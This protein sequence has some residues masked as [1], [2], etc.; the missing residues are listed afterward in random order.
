MRRL[1]AGLGVVS[2][3]VSACSADRNEADPG[4]SSTTTTSTTS[5]TVAGSTSLPPATT[6]TVAP[7][8]TAPPP[9]NEVVI[10]NDQEP[11]TLNPYAPGGDGSIVLEIAQAIH[12]GL[13]ERDGQTLEIVPDLAVEV[14]TVANGGVVVGD[15]GITT[16]TFRIRD[17]AVW[18]DGAP[19][20]GEDVVFTYEVIAGIEDRPN[21]TEPYE[22]ITAITADGKTVTLTFG[23]PTLAFETMFPTVIPAHQVRGT[24]VMADWNEVP[25]M[26]A[27]PFR[28][29]SWVPGDRI[30]LVR[31]DD[32]WKAGPDGTALPFLDRVVFRFI[33][34]AFMGEAKQS[35]EAF[36]SRA[37]DV[38]SPPPWSETVDRLRALEG[39]QVTVLES[40]VWEHWSFQF[41]ERNRNED[42]L[43]RYLDFRRAVAHAL[44][45]QAVMNLG[46]WE[47][48]RPRDAILDLHGLPTE[49]PW[50]QYDHNPERAR[51]LISDLCDRLGRDCEAN[52][53]VVVFSTTSNAEERPAI[54]HLAVEMLG[55]VGIEVHLEF[56]DSALFFGPTLATGTWDLGQWAWF[57]RPDPAGVLTSL[58]VY[59]PDA[60]LQ[61]DPNEDWQS[62]AGSNNARW[63]TPAVSGWPTAEEFGG[64]VDFNQGP[65]TVRDEHTVRYAEIIDRLA[66]TADRDEFAALAAEAEQILA[67]QV[68]VIPLIARN[69]A[70]AVWADRI[71]GYTHSTWLTTWNIETWRR[72]G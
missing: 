63:G 27:G 59:D 18:E 43:N 16:V 31:N 40:S 29:E 60:P 8:T 53:P 70:G 44:D 10:G 56:E 48:T 17:E 3:I 28:L 1:L 68:V 49:R 38:F 67:D 46:Y 14:T 42:S 19:V 54:A 64:V 9:P 34:E 36:E 35:I 25:W 33:G 69:T 52:P 2:L 5:T 11:P 22:A 15:D 50:S 57:A 4:T 20:T 6:T 51:A 32:Y 71:A 21:L 12:A 47:A 13:T 37:I 72:V 41:G 55:E 30:T 23:A 61:G 58:A 45:R 7:T 65:S 26:S 66:A 39:A 24:D 62:W